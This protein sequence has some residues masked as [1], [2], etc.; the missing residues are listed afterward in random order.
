MK[1]IRYTAML[2]AAAI[3]AS[4]QSP[5]GR[6]VAK[7]SSDD[8]V[9]E[10]VVALNVSPE[11]AISGYI[12][13]PQYEDRIV[14]GT[15]KDGKLAF[16]GER[17]ANNN[18]KQ[19]RNYNAVLEVGKLKLTMPSRGNQP[20]QVME[21]TRLSSEAPKPL[22]PAP[23]KISAAAYTPVKYNGLAKTPPMG[24]NS[25]N[26]FRG[27]V[28]D[29]VVREIADAMVS[30]GMK[31]AGYLYVNIDDTW[32]STRDERGNIRS[33]SKFPD[34]KKLADY[35]HGKGLKLGIYSSPGPKTCAGYEGSFQ[36]ETQDA[37]TYAA[38]G[39]DYLKYDWCSAARVYEASAMPA[40]YAK[41]GAALLD[42]G[43][44][45]VY[46]LC[47]Y[48][49]ENVGEWG[50]KAGGNLWRTTGDISDRWQSLENIGFKQ[51]IGREKFAAPGHWNDPDM[52]EIGN[53]GMT[54]AEYRTHM[55]LWS[56]L[57]AP[58][59]AGNDLRDIKPSIL[60]ILTN[61]EVIAVDRDA[62]G[63]QG[64]RASQ[65]DTV[66]VWVRTLADGAYAAGLFNRGDATA[67]VTAKWSDLGISGSHAVR[68][69]WEHAD[70]GKFTD[71]FSADVPSH[72]V[73]FVRI[74]K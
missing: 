12:Q 62:L 7:A 23:P 57:A 30:S 68:D 64:V 44:D 5:T 66:E 17:D 51:Q 53:G 59:L 18:T 8:E 48:G 58:L 24:W 45:I 69:L 2:L 60:Q 33:N 36:H 13:A 43:R 74:A 15:A 73:V 29:Q 26:K 38:W 4:A 42:S 56:I 41:M 25:W 27:K 47:Q 40:A 63:K 67:K 71:A 37:K 65:E 1:L 54:D 16:V 6:W 21:F 39:I 49:L 10:I 14:E 22:P 72:G 46:S 9:R 28:N 61:K 70:R 3:A 19:K 52:L 55:A 50:A 11:G 31:D 20:P 35:V 34:M 32:E